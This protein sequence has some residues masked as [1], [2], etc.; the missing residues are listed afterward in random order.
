MIRT[1]PPEA[2]V[3]PERK[4]IGRR[5][6]VTERS[7]AP[8]VP[9]RVEVLELSDMKE[10]AGVDSQRPDADTSAQKWTTDAT[11]SLAARLHD[12]HPRATLA[13]V[14]RSIEDATARFTDAHVRLFLPILIERAA[15]T[16]LGAA[17]CPTCPTTTSA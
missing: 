6:N 15:S 7:T 5:G 2:Y 12:R 8:G 9:P 11:I 4:R 17:L 3:D 13:M 1:Y 14:Q 16:A 10:K